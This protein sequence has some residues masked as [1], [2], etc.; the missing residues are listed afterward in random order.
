MTTYTIRN[1]DTGKRV[2]N[3]C[4][5]A[6]FEGD[7]GKARAHELTE[8]HNRAYPQCQWKVTEENI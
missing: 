6:C 3:G 4:T 7:D 8:I 2:E 5:G 1:A